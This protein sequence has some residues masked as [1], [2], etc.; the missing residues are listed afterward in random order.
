MRT[1]YDVRVAIDAVVLVN[2]AVL[3][4]VLLPELGVVLDALAHS[5]IFLRNDESFGGS[6]GGHDVG[7]ERDGGM[8][9]VGRVREGGR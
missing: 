6:L 3:V 8:D 7:G 5:A 4:H 9:G 1:I 2:F